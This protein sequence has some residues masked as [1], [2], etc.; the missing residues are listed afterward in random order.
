MDRAIMLMATITIVC[1]LFLASCEHRN[2]WAVC[3]NVS[4]E[5]V[6][7]IYRD[8]VPLRNVQWNRATLPPASYS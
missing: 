7:E 1:L 5:V 8:K 6:C 4:G 3:H 2:R